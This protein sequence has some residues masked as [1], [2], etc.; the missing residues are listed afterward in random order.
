MIGH[1]RHC[2][3]IIRVIEVFEAGY[4][5][6]KTNRF[7]WFKQKQLQL[8]KQ[9]IQED[10]FNSRIR[11]VTGVDVAYAEDWA[12]GC[13][14]IMDQDLAQ[15]RVETVVQQVTTPYISG[16]FALREG[17]VIQ[18]LLQR[19][20]EP[21]LVLVDG[22]GILHPRRCGLASSVGVTLDVP[23]IGVAKTLLLGTIGLRQ[24]D[25]APIRVQDEILGTALWG[26]GRTKPVFVSVGHRVSLATA[27]EV[28]RQ[29]MLR[30]YPEPLQRAHHEATVLKGKKSPPV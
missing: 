17:P 21:G 5:A 12:F 23:T 7:D 28:V 10:R 8:G 19:I 18:E 30:G 27:V 3:L 25:N 26:S 16:L 24:G 15:V 29:A 13:A 4:L 6:R 20:P 14:V 22:N 11:Q 1:Y 9:V 2:L